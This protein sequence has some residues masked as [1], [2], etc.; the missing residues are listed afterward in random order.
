MKYYS[1]SIF[2]EF[3]ENEVL[4]GWI[5][6]ED[7][8][9]IHFND[10]NQLL[11][12]FDEVCN[13]TTLPQSAVQLRSFTDKERVIE[14]SKRNVEDLAFKSNRIIQVVITKRQNASWQGY[15]IVNEERIDFKSELEFIEILKQI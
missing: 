14:I 15:A 3:E 1:N 9:P 10:L 8:S 4:K 6:R 2:I 7:L 5:K 11:V 13:N 12:L